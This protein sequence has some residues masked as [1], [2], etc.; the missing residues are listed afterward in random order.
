MT[1]V[2]PARQSP[3]TT[4]LSNRPPPLAASLHSTQ[5]LCKCRHPIESDPNAPRG[6][7]IMRP[8]NMQQLPRSALAEQLQQQRQRNFGFTDAE[9]M[10]LLTRGVKPWEAGDQG[11]DGPGGQNPGQFASQGP[12]GQNPGQFPGQHMPQQM[13][14]NGAASQAA[15][16]RGTSSAAGTPGVDN[17]GQNSM[18]SALQNLHLDSSSTN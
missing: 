6:S 17:T 18:L 10:D 2:H 13:P 12:V 16:S 7:G 5:L 11:M 4:P 8:A 14:Q 9:M 3:H 1:T 15:P